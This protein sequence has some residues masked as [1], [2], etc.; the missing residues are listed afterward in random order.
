M[1]TYDFKCDE[2]GKVDEYIVPL[3]TST[4]D[5]CS[6]EKGCKNLTKIDS[7]CTNN[8]VYKVAGFYQTDY[9]DLNARIF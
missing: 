2:C 7:F 4:P 1:P 9:V 5:K 6:C 8:P 3:T